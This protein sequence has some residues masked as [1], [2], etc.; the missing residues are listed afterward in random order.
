MGNAVTLEDGREI[1]PEQVLG[2][3]EPG[4]KLCFI[5]DVSHTGPLHKIAQDSDLLVIEATYLDEDKELAKQHSH[6]TAGAAARLARNAEVKHLVLHHVSRRYRTN[7]ILQEAQAI[8]PNTHVANDLDLFR[9]RKGKGVTVQD[10]DY[11]CLGR[12]PAPNERIVPRVRATERLTFNTGLTTLSLTKLVVPLTVWIV[13]WVSCNIGLIS[14][15]NIRTNRQ[16]CQTRMT[17]NV[18]MTMLWMAIIIMAMSR[19][20]ALIMDEFYLLK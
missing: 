12:S 16:T 18:P 7:D 8:F 17:N 6:I 14:V 4:A 3:P 5:S 10:V 19:I 13:S 11:F 2:D 1:D 20:V 9:V 15:C